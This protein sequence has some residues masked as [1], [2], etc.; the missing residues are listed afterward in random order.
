MLGRSSLR[1]ILLVV[2]AATLAAPVL[3]LNVP[4]DNSAA[5]VEVADLKD[6]LKNGL[7]ARRPEEH[8][9]IDRVVQMVRNDDLPMDL[10][11][12]TFQWARKS[13]KPYPFP[14]FERALRLRAAEIGIEIK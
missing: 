5:A 11:K 2:F 3:I 6:Q 12:S 14:Y 7:Q 8:A 9:F 13:K 1:G 4:Q 10:V